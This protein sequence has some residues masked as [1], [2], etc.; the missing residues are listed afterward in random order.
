MLKNLC[1]KVHRFSSAAR[2]SLVY[3]AVVFVFLANHSLAEEYAPLPQKKPQQSTEVTEND[4][5]VIQYSLKD[6][7]K[8]FKNEATPPVPGIKPAMIATASSASS[9]KNDLP[10]SDAEIYK[11]VFAMQ[12]AGKMDKALSEM[13]SVKDMRL[14]GHVLYQRYMHPTAYTSSFDELESWLREYADH[15]GAEK[16][17]ALAQNKKP[18][19]FVGAIHKPEKHRGI[20]RRLEPMM[21]AARSY[22][23]SKIRSNSEEQKVKKLNNSI[24]RLVR[25]D[26][27]DQA[28]QTLSSDENMGLLDV[29]ERDILQAKIATRLLHDGNLDKAY[30]LASTS[31]KR[32]GIQVPT[33]GWVAGLSSW[34]KGDYRK[35]AEYFEITARSSYA[36]GW[37]TSAGAYWAARAHMKAGQVKHVSQWLE[38]AAEHPRTFYGLIATR[39]LGR[40]FDFNWN[41]PT[42]TKNY[43]ETLSKTP[44]G[45]RAIALVEAGQNH[46]AE[47]ELLQV[48][49]E[50]SDMHDALLSYSG[51]AGLP[52]L[53]MRIGSAYE[54]SDG[55]YYDAALYPKSSWKPKN[56]YKIDPALIHAIMRQ[57]SR[58][59]YRA[60][61]PSGARGLMQ[62]MPATAKYV[63]GDKSL[64]MNK[65][66][67]PQYNV[68]LGEKYLTKLLRERKVSGNLISLLIAYNAGPGNLSR[69]K[70]EWSDVN[71][72]LL[73]IELIPSKETRAYVERVLSNYWIYRLREGVPT[74]TLDAIAQGKKASYKEAQAASR[75]NMFALAQSA[76]Q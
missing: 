26:S 72:P 12:A 76:Q 38:R 58:F 13:G 17:Y 30:A 20:S 57:E 75:D 39:A 55:M 64:N 60:E 19:D 3:G 56:G 65:L 63:A 69:W 42:F 49:P 8:A 32:S 53:A 7:A 11:R 29:V 62:L 18:S 44:A 21:V 68:E 59:D 16:I 2:F 43:H 45:A 51:Y 74:P 40:D 37:T 24:S 22:Q 28:Y 34:G 14:K 50:T 41:V 9:M 54:A 10:D 70:R 4:R 67:E 35:A 47:S 27:P 33:A 23:S 1:S 15:P 36:S 52:A 6:F 46:L 5:G 31:A 61:S 73:F 71:D 48:R 66:M 25:N